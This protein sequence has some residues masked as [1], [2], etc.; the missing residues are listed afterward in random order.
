METRETAPYQ[1]TLTNREYLQANGIVE[2]ESFDEQEILAV[3]KLGPLIIKGQGLH[4]IQLSL[5]EGKL[6]LEGEI[7]S[8][9]YSN[10]KKG[11]M[12]EKGR[13]VLERLFK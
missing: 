5:E 11:K 12:K 6:T 4:I 9:Q 8:I 1:L 2:V 3:S 7:V 10:S 13:G